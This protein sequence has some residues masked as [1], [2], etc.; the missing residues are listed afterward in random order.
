MTLFRLLVSQEYPILVG[1]K[2]ETNTDHRTQGDQPQQPVQQTHGS[3]KNSV[4]EQQ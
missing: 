2:N 4:V 3:R 1:P